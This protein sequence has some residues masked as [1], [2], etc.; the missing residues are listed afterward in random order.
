MGRR[1]SR[2]ARPG[3]TAQ[4]HGTSTRSPRDGRACALGDK[5]RDEDDPTGDGHSIH[6]ESVGSASGTP[7][8]YLHG[9]PR[10]GAR[11]GSRRYFDHHGCRAVSSDQPASQWLCSCPRTARR[12]GSSS[13]SPLD[14]LDNWG[15]VGRPVERRDPVDPGGLG[16]SDQVRPGEVQSVYFVDPDS[17]QQQCRV[18][19]HH[20]AHRQGRPGCFG[21]L[22]TRRLSKDPKT[23]TV[24][25]TAKSVRNNWGSLRRYDVAR[26][27]MSAGSPVR[28]RARMTPA[29][30]SL[31]M[32]EALEQGLHEVLAELGHTGAVL[33]GSI[34]K[35]TIHCQSHGGYC[36][37]DLVV[38]HGPYE[39]WT[40]RQDGTRP[41]ADAHRRPV[42]GRGWSRAGRHTGRQ[43]RD[44]A[45][46]CRRPHPGQHPRAP[47][48]SLRARRPART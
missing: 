29:N 48:S 14:S 23:C 11:P 5:E 9:G 24:S 44:R 13:S 45:A 41:H 2:S 42:P 28:W 36:R 19:A 43:A 18:N 10:S 8:V 6:R 20:E 17:P 39:T 16:P 40:R 33:P 47:R 27:A 26:P 30:I 7:T 31:G 22:D 1:R 32:A 12:D 15:P 3:R 35:R 46:H 21:H 34:S 38:L 25:A 4:G 37:T